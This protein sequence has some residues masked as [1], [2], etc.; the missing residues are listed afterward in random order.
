[1]TSL[2]LPLTASL[3][4]GLATAAVAAEST[5][6]LPMRQGNAATFYI[7]AGVGDL[8]IMEFMVDTG[9]GYMTI[10]EATLA[11]LQQTGQ[12]EYRRDLRGVLANGTEIQVP[13][14]R[15]AQLSLGGCLLSDVEAAV[16]PGK[17]RQ[18]LGL[19]A[20]RQAGAFTFSFD[21][22]QLQLSDCRQPSTLA[23]AQE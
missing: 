15:L 23:A 8:G 14:Y 4:L 3:T 5:T 1:M 16:F 10:N 7:E 12:A 21:P 18:I 19:N 13:V 20:L 9:S 6:Q 2:I 11:K 22:P 17:T